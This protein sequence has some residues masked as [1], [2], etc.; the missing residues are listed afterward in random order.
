M[1]KLLVFGLLFG[2]ALGALAA[3]TDTQTV[4]IEIQALPDSITVPP[5]A[6]TITLSVVR[7]GD[8]AASTAFT[9][10]YTTDYTDRDITVGI[11]S[12]TKGGSPTTLPSGLTLSIKYGDAGSWQN[13]WDGTTQCTVNLVQNLS[14]GVDVFTDN[15]YLQAQTSNVASGDIGTYV[16]TITYTITTI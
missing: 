3:T 14:A 13:L 4:N 12:V 11:T 1:R 2:I 10:T 15:I 8:T 6:K 16:V 9:L 7:Q 5:G